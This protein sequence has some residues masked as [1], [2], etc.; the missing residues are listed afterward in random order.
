MNGATGCSHECS[1][2]AARQNERHGAQRS[3]LLGGSL[4]LADYAQ[5]KERTR[6]RFWDATS[7]ETQ[8]K[9]LDKLTNWEQRE[10]CGSELFWV[11]L[12]HSRSLPKLW[13]NVNIKKRGFCAVYCFPPSPFLASEFP[14]VKNTKRPFSWR[15]CLRWLTASFT[16]FRAEI[17]FIPRMNSESTFIQ[18]AFSHVQCYRLISEWSSFY[19]GVFFAHFLCLS[20]H[21]GRFW[22]TVGV[23]CADV[24]LS[25]RHW[26]CRE[27]PWESLNGSLSLPVVR[28]L[29]TPFAVVVCG[30][31]FARL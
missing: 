28:R 19:H 3:S 20:S 2:S 16:N 13:T 10:P 5:W 29:S 22:L 27:S 9:A 31:L 25:T 30:P 21:K 11:F 12:A 24:A 8:R 17:L 4:V 1:F 6:L 15:L 18:D 7:S 26:N 14:F 23:K